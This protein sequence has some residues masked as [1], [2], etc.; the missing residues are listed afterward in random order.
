[1]KKTGDNDD[2]SSVLKNEQCPITVQYTK[3]V[4]EDLTTD[5]VEMN[6]CIKKESSMV[7]D[8]TEYA[9]DTCENDDQ[10]EIAVLNNQMQLEMK[11]III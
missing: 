4:D 11:K 7:R 10:F 1:V 6:N 9:S 5:C 2:Y 8:D 3:S